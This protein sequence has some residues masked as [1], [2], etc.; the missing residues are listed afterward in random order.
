MSTKGKADGWLDQETYFRKQLIAVQLFISIHSGITCPTISK[1]YYT[2]SHSHPHIHPHHS[3]T[4]TCP[5]TTLPMKKCWWLVC[6]QTQSGWKSFCATSGGIDQDARGRCVELIDPKL[7]CDPLYLYLYLYLYM[8]LYLYLHCDL[9]CTDPDPLC[10]E[11][12]TRDYL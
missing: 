6:P 7:H 1:K 4:T 5:T 11:I 8:Y 12:K 9:F 2:T 3:V 10:T